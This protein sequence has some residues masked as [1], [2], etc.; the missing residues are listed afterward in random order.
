MRMKKI[1]QNLMAFI[2]KTSAHI[3][4]PYNRKK[5]DL[6]KYFELE[7]KLRDSLSVPF[8][9]GLVSTDGEA[10]NIFI[11][12]ANLFASNKKKSKSK[13]T[14]SFAYIDCINGYKHRVAEMTVNGFIINPLLSAIGQRDNVIIRV[15][16]ELLMPESVRRYAKDYLLGLAKKDEEGNIE[17]DFNHDNKDSEKMDCSEMIFLALKYGYEKAD[18]RFPMM[19]ETRLGYEAITPTDLEYSDL[20]VTIYDS[21]KGFLDGSL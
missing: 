6:N 9:I 20:F 1:V 3:H 2:G 19:M 21:K 13:I 17:Y 5:L 4:M 10:S 12:A 11:K 16:N 15:P 14:H 8:A 7:K 18:I